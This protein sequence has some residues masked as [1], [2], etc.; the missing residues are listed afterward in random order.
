[1]LLTRDGDGGTAALYLAVS[2]IAG[3]VAVA[4]GVAL[5]RRLFGD[6][7]PAFDPERD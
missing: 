3:L 1:M 7:V 2:L 6:R 5:A 4:L